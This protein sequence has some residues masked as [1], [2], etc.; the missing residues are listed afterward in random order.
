MSY[1][2]LETQLYV[3][4]SLTLYILSATMYRHICLNMTARYVSD[5]AESVPQWIYAG[6]NLVVKP[7]PEVDV[8]AQCC[9]TLPAH[10]CDYIKP[11]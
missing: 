6:L 2:S 1:H 3:C 8:V 9:T 4:D 5:L 11:V 10:S 7:E